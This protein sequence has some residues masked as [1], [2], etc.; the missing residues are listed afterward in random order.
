MSSIYSLGVVASAGVAGDAR[1]AT[2]AYPSE[3]RGFVNL[4]TDLPTRA[5]ADRLLRGHHPATVSLYLPTAIA[6]RVWLNGGRVRAVRRDD[7]LRK[8]P[9]AAI[10]RYP[11]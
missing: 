3:R 9:A 11:I 1:D 7:I 8:S 10:L 2:L 6:R 4:H 5:Q